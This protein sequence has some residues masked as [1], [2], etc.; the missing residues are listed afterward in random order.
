MNKKTLTIVLILLAGIFLASVIIAKKSSHNN[1]EEDFHPYR[2]IFSWN[3][4]FFPMN[5]AEKNMTEE[6]RQEYGQRIEAM[7]DEWL[8][9]RR[10]SGQRKIT[11]PDMGIILR[12]YNDKW[13]FVQATKSVFVPTDMSIGG[14]RLMRSQAR[15]LVESDTWEVG[16]MKIRFKIDET[17]NVFFSEN[18]FSDINNERFENFFVNEVKTWKFWEHPNDTTEMLI[19][20]RFALNSKPHADTIWRD[21]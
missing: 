11:I 16:N 9:I 14:E 18:V 21:E 20:F 15:V 4:G 1:E 19:D 5:T 2:M 6:E 3:L 8:G 7:L 10:I 13:G 17:G 12:N